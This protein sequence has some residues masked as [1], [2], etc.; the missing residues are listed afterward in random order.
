[1]LSLTTWDGYL[2]AMQLNMLYASTMRSPMNHLSRQHFFAD[3]KKG[4]H[5]TSLKGHRQRPILPGRVQPSTFGTGELN[6]CVRNGNRWDLSVI[7]TGKLSGWPAVTRFPSLVLL[8]FRSASFPF[9]LSASLPFRFPRSVLRFLLL[10]RSR[11]LRFLPF[12][13]LRFLSGPFSS[14]S[15]LPGALLRS[16]LSASF[17]FPASPL[18]SLSGS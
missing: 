2:P 10:F 13:A 3:N 14:A 7:V 4:S 11:S 6:Y 17:P 5:T 18:P 16:S 15:A 1:M 9:G 12:R 8:P